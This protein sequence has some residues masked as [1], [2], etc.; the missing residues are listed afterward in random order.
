MTTRK[1]RRRGFTLAE[2]L[3]A[4]LVLGML[5][6]AAAVGVSGALRSRQQVI[7]ASNARM[8][9]SAA[10][11]ILRT[12]LRYA[13]KLESSEHDSV[14]S[15]QKPYLNGGRPTVRIGYSKTYGPDATIYLDNNGMLVLQKLK[16]NDTEAQEQLN[17]PP[18]DLPWALSSHSYNGLKLAD[19]SIELDS[20]KPIATV[21]LSVEDEANKDE[22]NKVLWHQEIAVRL[23]NPPSSS[24]AGGSPGEGGGS[25]DS[26]DSGAGDGSEPSTE[27]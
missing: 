20:T 25:G 24:D 14:E 2:M 3:I 8:L 16:E 5:S 11:Q 15:V 19:L 23:L 22:A 10:M 17:D 27:S 26:G 9:G 4:T 7:A 13:R 21:N 18:P 12:E 1:R 6:S